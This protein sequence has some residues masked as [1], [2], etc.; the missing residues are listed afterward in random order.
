MTA[1]MRRLLI[2]GGFLAVVLAAGAGAR[3]RRRCTRSCRSCSCSS[4]RGWSPAS[5]RSCWLLPMSSRSR[6]RR[7]SG[8]HYLALAAREAARRST[9][10]CVAV[11]GSFGKTSTKHILAQLLQPSVNT[12]P[13]RKSFNTLM[14]VSRVINEDLDARASRLRRRDGRVRA[15]GDRGDQRP[16][17]SDG[18]DRHRDRS[19]AH[20]AL[21]HA[22]PHRR[23]DVR[24]R[25]ARCPPTAR[26]IVY[27][28]DESCVGAGAARAQ[29][30]QRHA[31]PLRARGRRQPSDA[32]VVASAIRIDAH[33]ATFQWRWAA[34]GLDRAGHASRCSAATRWPTSARR[35][36]RCT[37]SATPSMRRSPLRRR[38]S[39]SSIVCELMATAGPL[40]VIDNSYNANPVGVHN[41]LEVLAA[42][43]GAHEVPDHAGARRARQRRGRGEPPLRRA[44]GDGV[45][46]RHRHVGEDER[47]ACAPGSRDGG[48]SEDRIHV[49]DTLAD[50][51]AV[52]QQPVAVPGTW[53]SSPTISRTRTCRR[54]ARSRAR[55]VTPASPGG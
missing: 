21:R 53:C 13:T 51:T 19:A 44:R 30:E 22:R 3:H 40:T 14:G 7:G 35:S 12:L 27:T 45:R 43:R 49:V 10:W 36:P 54:R 52:L 42:M 47:G 29:H 17:A 39:R 9:R 23:R 41:G 28:G 24:G 6:R 32:D 25:R 20:G 46:P 37:R 55:A 38:C 34:G 33:G 2:A 11:V 15:G 26:S 8:K 4:P 50:A 1:R 31:D 18:R 48:M 5:A 16:R